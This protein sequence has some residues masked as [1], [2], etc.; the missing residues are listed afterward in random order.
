MN[1]KSNLLYFNLYTFHSRYFSNIFFKA[2]IIYINNRKRSNNSFYINIIFDSLG[3]LINNINNILIAAEDIKLNTPALI[4]NY[5]I[6]ISDLAC[7]SFS[8]YWYKIPIYYKIIN[9]YKFKFIYLGLKLLLNLSLR[10]YIGLL[11]YFPIL[12]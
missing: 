5:N 4:N 9:V 11:L 2:F 10:I 1:I 12:V 7:Y 6:I 3:P 8:Y